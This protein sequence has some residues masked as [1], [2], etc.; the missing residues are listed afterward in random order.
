M[1]TTRSDRQGSGRER[2]AAGTPPPLGIE[3][4]GELLPARA[5]LN[6][7]STGGGVTV[8]D[9][10]TNNSSDVFLPA[11]TTSAP[12]GMLP[13]DVQAV[14]NAVSPEVGAKGDGVTDDSAALAG[15]ARLVANGGAIYISSD[16]LIGTS[17]TLPLLQFAPGG[18]LT[19][20]DGVAVTM[21]AP[22]AGLTQTIF[23]FTVGSTGQPQ[24]AVT[25]NPPPAQIIPRW[26]GAGTGS[27]DTGPLQFAVNTAAS[28]SLANFNASVPVYLTRGEQAPDYSVVLGNITVPAGVTICSDGAVIQENLSYTYTPASG[29]P[30]QIRGGMMFL[31]GTDDVTFRGLRFIGST[32]NPELTQPAQQGSGLDYNSNVYLIFAA[33][34]SG[35]IN[36]L[37]I[38]NC[39]FENCNASYPAPPPQA[40]MPS[41]VAVTHPVYLQNV[42]YGR[43]TGCT[44]RPTGTSLDNTSSPA[45]PNQMSCSGPGVDVFTSAHVLI[46]NNLFIDTG[47][48]A[49]LLEEG[50]LDVQVTDNIITGVNPNCRREGGSIDSPSNNSESS[51]GESNAGR[52]LRIRISGNYISGPTAYSGPG[53]IRVGANDGAII[54]NNIIDQVAP[55]VPSSGQN[56]NSAISVD[57]RGIT[58]TDGLD[59]DG[60]TS[61]VLQQNVIYCGSTTTVGITVENQQA[62]GTNNSPSTGILVSENIIRSTPNPSSPALSYSFGC[63]ISINAASGGLNYVCVR[64]NIIEAT[65]EI[66]GALNGGLYLAGVDPG[67][68]LQEVIATGNHIFYP[69][70]ASTPTTGAGILM[71]GLVNGIV[72]DNTIDDFYYGIYDDCTH[73]TQLGIQKNVVNGVAP[74]QTLY[75]AE[76]QYNYIATIVLSGK[77]C[78]GQTTTGTASVAGAQ[79]GQPVT[80]LPDATNPELASLTWSAWVSTA[81]TVTLAVQNPTTDEVSP[82]G[83]WTVIVSPI[84]SV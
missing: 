38:V 41:S 18:K 56:T 28:S 79:V 16:C 60:S 77:L 40:P 13:E 15:A 63:G 76:P 80:V 31:V 43:V 22:I 74:S 73:G 32:S 84:L 82:A 3:A 19:L 33:L 44:F 67:P 35:A 12:G 21:P 46:A 36:N 50:N 81:G 6:F 49:I 62:T 29:S 45:N 53:G 57:S 2:T 26:W 23:A 70:G 7:V 14:I 27:D 61:V 58:P 11:R 25:F 75:L 20:A 51:G 17:C 78:G 30:M 48:A 37:R 69:A 68:G 47:W 83:R 64:D 1:D 4:N 54:E 66:E 42:N 59:I 24:A 8:V 65:G 10:P 39:Q 52:N 72:R 71:Q 34:Q 55:P 9:D 5:Y